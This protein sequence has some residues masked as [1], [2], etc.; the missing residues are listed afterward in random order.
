MFRAQHS[1]LG[2]WKAG[3]EFRLVCLAGRLL[4]I[5][6]VVR[7]LR[8]PHVLVTARLLRAFRA[9]IGPGTTFK[10]G[11]WLDSVCEDRNSAGDFSHLQIGSRCYIGEGV[12]FDLANTVSIGGNTM[13]SAK[14]SFVTH[15]DCGRSQYLSGQFPRKC[16]PVLVGEGVWIGFG[17]TILPGVTVGQNTV[18]GAHALLRDNADAESLYAG[19]PAL[20]IRKLEARESGSAEASV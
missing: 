2:R 19:V 7:Y 8:N 10:G 20:L 16:A 12:Y 1:I 5:G 13:A 6:S 15:A 17:A 3:V 18:I 4:G 11:V 9:T 14:A